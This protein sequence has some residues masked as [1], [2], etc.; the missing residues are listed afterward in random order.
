MRQ[1]PRVVLSGPGTSLAGEGLEGTSATLQVEFKVQ[2]Q[3]EVRMGDERVG[4]WF[5]GSYAYPLIHV[6]AEGID[7]PKYPNLTYRAVVL[8]GCRSDKSTVDASSYSIPTSRELMLERCSRES[9]AAVRTRPTVAWLQAYRCRGQW[10]SKAGGSEAKQS[11]K[12]FQLPE[13]SPKIT[14]IASLAN[15]YPLST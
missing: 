10:T 6:V 5:K 12:E 15:F 7:M 8:G 1:G 4:A 3:I 11:K 9:E 2:R 14:S 13:S